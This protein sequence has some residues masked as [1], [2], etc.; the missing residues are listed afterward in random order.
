MGR[1]SKIISIARPKP[2][3]PFPP[4][5]NVSKLAKLGSI[6][7]GFSLLGEGE[8]I[9]AQ[10]SDGFGF[11]AFA[12]SNKWA[13]GG[14]IGSSLGSCPKDVSSILTLGAT[15]FLLAFGFGSRVFLCF[16]LAFW[17]WE[18]S[19]SGRTAAF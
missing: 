4:P 12:H 11:S 19:S 10:I 9:F 2:P 6:S 16:L 18:H 17:K 14:V 5:P 7:T 8:S 15:H 1:K 13:R 3:L